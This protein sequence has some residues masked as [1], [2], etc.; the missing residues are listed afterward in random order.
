MTTIDNVGILGKIALSVGATEPALKLLLSILV[1]EC[2]PATTITL[3]ESQ[4]RQRQQQQ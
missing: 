1:G 4:E 2:H 3:N